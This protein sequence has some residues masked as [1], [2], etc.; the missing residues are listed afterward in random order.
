M[1][2]FSRSRRSYFGV[3]RVWRLVH[4]TRSSVCVCRVI[5]S[6]LDWRGKRQKGVSKSAN[7]LWTG[8][9]IRKVR[10]HVL[11]PVNVSSVI[12]SRKR[13]SVWLLHCHGTAAQCKTYLPWPCTALP[14]AITIQSLSDYLARSLSWDWTTET[15]RIRKKITTL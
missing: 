3:C 9:Q 10:I 2:Q 7:I 12:K 15:F 4:R 1:S 13:Q 5:K 8:K 11:P 14:L 6:R